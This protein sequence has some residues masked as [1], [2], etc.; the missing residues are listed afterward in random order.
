MTGRPTARTVGHVRRRSAPV[1]RRTPRL[2]A[3]RAGGLLVMLAAGG[4]VYGL[5]TSPVFGLDR[6]VVEGAELTGDAAVRQA[7]GLA[8]GQRLVT[9]RTDELVDRVEALP[10]IADARL[11][12]G[13]PGTVTIDVVERRPI[14]AWQVGDRRLLLDVDG[15]AVAEQGLDATLP[16][17]GELDGGGLIPVIVDARERSRV[18]TGSSLSPVILDAAR[19][20]GSLTPS[21][22]GSTA[23]ALT[24]ALSDGSGWTVSPTGDADVG[25][26]AVFGFYTSD[27]ATDLRP[28]SVI[29]AQ[30]RLLRS[31]LADRETAVGR[32]IL[33]SETE[34]TYVPRVTP[35]PS[36]APSPS[37]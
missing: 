9:L 10:A 16:R 4:A 11:R 35:A 22:L 33:A 24:V 31:L 19:R 25:W 21:D 14:L 1:R 13:L 3:A 17:L 8:I 6:V 26:V 28:T 29:P 5:A 2:T 7:A 27:L 37:P 12:V 15:E 36:P 20:L 30:V 18:R 34:G 23:P 32:V